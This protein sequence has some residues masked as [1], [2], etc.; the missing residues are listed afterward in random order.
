M[1]A[2]LFDAL[3]VERHRLFLAA[4]GAHS[5]SY[6]SGFLGG[7]LLCVLIAAKRLRLR[8]L[9]RRRSKLRFLSSAGSGARRL[10]LYAPTS[11]SLLVL[12][13]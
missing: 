3:P 10:E 7:I 12:S 1:P 4:W 2:Q 11:S 9:S 6:V 13:P 8:A 5:A